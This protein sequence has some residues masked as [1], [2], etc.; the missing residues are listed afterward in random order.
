MSQDEVARFL[1]TVDNLKYS[2]ILTVCYATGLRISEAVRLTPDAIDSKRMVSGW[3]R[4]RVARTAMS[5]CRRG[6]SNCCGT[7]GGVLVPGPPNQAT[8]S[9]RS[10]ALGGTGISRC[11]FHSGHTLWESA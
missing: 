8:T 7:I 1:A 5:C 10:S 3:R 9:P 11:I 4:A 6:C 2:V